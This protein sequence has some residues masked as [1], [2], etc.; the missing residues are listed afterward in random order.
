MPDNQEYI[1]LKLAFEPFANFEQGTP[2]RV[3]PEGTWYRGTRKLE[4]TKN[5]LL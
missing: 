1:S 5:R 4:V 3:L 2:I